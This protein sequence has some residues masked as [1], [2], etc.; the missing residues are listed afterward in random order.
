MDQSASPLPFGPKT[1]IVFLGVMACLFN[2]ILPTMLERSQSELLVGL[3]LG[4]LPGQW[5]LLVIWAA[6]GPRPAR[7]QLPAAILLAS[8]LCFTLVMG[9]AMEPHIQSPFSRADYRELMRILL[10]LPVF[11]AS[12]SPLWLMRILRGWRV[13]RRGAADASAMAKWRQLRLQQL[14]ILTALMA[15]VL[16]SVQL[17]IRAEPGLGARQTLSYWLG[18]A[19]ACGIVAVWSAATTIPCL[20]AVFRAPDPASGLFGLGGYLLAVTCFVLAP[21]MGILGGNGSPRMGLVLLALLLFHVSFLGVMF[22]G[23]HLARWCGYVLATSR[24]ASKP[25]H[26]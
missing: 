9:M 14:L 7:V 22:G 17:T 13:V 19:I 1:A 12:Q 16:G 4:V 18:L 3:L 20:L 6:L 25:E 23:L 15:V 11:L 26:G 5:G 21:L 2:L 10:A 24:H 8:L